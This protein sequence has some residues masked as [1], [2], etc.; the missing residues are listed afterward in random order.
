MAKEKKKIIRRIKMMF[1]N[2]RNLPLTKLKKKAMNETTTK[3]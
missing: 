2:G 1:I 3:M